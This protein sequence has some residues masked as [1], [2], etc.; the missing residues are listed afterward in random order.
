[1]A[2]KYCWFFSAGAELDAW[3][4]VAHMPVDDF[5]LRAAD[6]RAGIERPH[7]PWSR[8][9]QQSYEAFQ[10]SIRD[11]ATKLGKTPLALEHEWWTG[12]AVH[13]GK[14]AGQANA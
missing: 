7:K 12:E 10:S 13:A 2:I 1:M 11:H 8:W 5:I 4:S 6:E 3:Y 14:R 9:D